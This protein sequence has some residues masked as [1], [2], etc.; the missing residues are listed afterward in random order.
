MAHTGLS[1]MMFF[2][3]TFK[4]RIVDEL[5]V[6][7]QTC[8]CLSTMCLFM[9]LQFSTNGKLLATLST[10]DQ[11]FVSVFGSL[12]NGEKS[13][14]LVRLVTFIAREWSVATVSCAMILKGP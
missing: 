14:Y 6:T 3:M 11:F 13:L 9:F 2:Y 5:S 8:V 12:V 1:R 10:W 4:S 7:L